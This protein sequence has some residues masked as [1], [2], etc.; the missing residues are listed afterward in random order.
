MHPPSFSLL[1]PIPS[2]NFAWD[3]VIGGVM[4]VRI[5]MFQCLSTIPE[6]T[7]S[8]SHAGTIFCICKNHNLLLLLHSISLLV[9]E[10]VHCPLPSLFLSPKNIIMFPYQ[11]FTIKLCAHPTGHSVNLGIG[12]KCRIGLCVVLM[13]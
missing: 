1:F 10:F 2:V 13:V 7:T 3:H 5:A 8:S 11:H 12:V 9:R 4:V 6:F